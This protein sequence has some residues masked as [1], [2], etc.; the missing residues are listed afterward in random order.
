VEQDQ[1]KCSCKAKTKK[2]RKENW[3][4]LTRKYIH[5]AACDK[6]VAEKIG[7]FDE[8]YSMGLNLLP[9]ESSNLEEVSRGRKKISWV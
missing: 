7:F 4:V 5:T 8:N 3:N 9:Q 1:V 2:K 6:Q